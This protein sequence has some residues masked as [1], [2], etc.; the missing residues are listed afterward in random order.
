MRHEDFR[1]ALGSLDERERELFERHTDS[2]V[3]CASLSTADRQG[4]RF[5]LEAVRGLPTVP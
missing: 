2:M 4:A 5:Y 1:R 3:S